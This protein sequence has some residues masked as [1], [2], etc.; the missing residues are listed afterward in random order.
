MAIMKRPI[1]SE[2]VNVKK[3]SFFNSLRRDLKKNYV[4]YLLILPAVVMVLVF[5]YFPMYGVIIAFKNFKPALGIFGSKWVGFDNFTRFFSSYQFWDILKNTLVISIYSLIA[6]FP[7]P[8]ILAIMINQIKNSKYKKTL[9]TITYMPHF[10]STVVV[11]GMLTLFLNPSTGLYGH[12][13]AFLGVVQPQDL[14]AKPKWFSSIYVLSDVWQHAG[15]DSIIYLAT[16]SS[17]DVSIYE[18]ATVDGANARQRI[19][20]IDIPAMIPTT[21]ILLILRVGGIMNVGFEKVF[22]LQNNLN[23][24]NSEVISTY[25]YKVGMINQ[26]YSFSASAD[27]F[28]TVINFILLIT[29]NQISKK[30]SETS[31][32]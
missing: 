22:L 21:V 1:K 24:D 7:A 28:N 13:M 25:V 31:L 30:V 20:N 9:Q 29:V 32:W 23:I 6:T 8:I 19:W 5:S 27:L 26:Q 15:W 3:N 12:I 2:V 18:A 11:C 10:I 17:V 14:L 16:L 4:L